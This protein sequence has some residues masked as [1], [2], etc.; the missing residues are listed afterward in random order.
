MERTRPPP[1]SS[2]DPEVL[3][4]VPPALPSLSQLLEVVRGPA[5]MK[6]DVDALAEALARPPAGDETPRERA[7]L[8]LSLLEDPELRDY[9]GSDGR[10]V[11]TLAVEALL[12]LGYP[13][14]LEIPP[15]ALAQ[16][17][18]AAAGAAQEPRTPVAGLFTGGL[19]LLTQVLLGLWGGGLALGGG[20]PRPGLLLYMAGA[21]L[22]PTLL[23]VLGGWRGLRWPQLVGVGLMVVVGLA[24]LTRFAEAAFLP[25]LGAYDDR[26][27]ATGAPAVLL[28]LSA[29]L[30]RKPWRE[31]EP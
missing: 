14:A 6:S 15:E 8:L 22:L 1:S 28:L 25:P 17:R 10:R 23:A 2:E 5:V 21:L 16:A 11:R 3:S 24:W 7:D 13:Y 26:E 18:P 31:E 9:T 20:E 4:G 27:L 30:L 12:A 29:W 19:A